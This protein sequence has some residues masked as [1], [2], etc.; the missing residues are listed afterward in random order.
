M[1]RPEDED[2]NDDDRRTRSLAG[3]AFLLLLLVIGLAMTQKLKAVSN[4]EDCL[5]SGRSNC[6]PIDTDA[7][8]R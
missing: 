1:R 7:L 2:E 8:A 4:L 3:L 5:M 6:A